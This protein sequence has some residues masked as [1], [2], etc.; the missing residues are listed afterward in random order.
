MSNP[1]KQLR[2]QLRQVVKEVLPEVLTNEFIKDLQNQSRQQ[3]EFIQ[4]LVEDT[5]TRIDERQKNVQSMIMREFSNPAQP[6][7]FKKQSTPDET[8]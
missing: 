1:A 2:S 3:L 6:E 8:I 7:A 4:K 5:L